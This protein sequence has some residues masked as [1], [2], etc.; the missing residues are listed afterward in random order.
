MPSSV[1]KL[2]AELAEHKRQLVPSVAKAV[3]YSVAGAFAM[4]R[5]LVKTSLS[6]E[7][8]LGVAILVALLPPAIVGIL[9]YRLSRRK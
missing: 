3:F 9:W 5:L 2:Q 7:L 6:P 8:A 4:H 1:E